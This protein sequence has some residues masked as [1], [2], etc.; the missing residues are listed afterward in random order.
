MRAFTTATAFLAETD[1]KIIVVPTRFPVP[2]QQA[3]RVAYASSHA[4]TSSLAFPDGLATRGFV[5]ARTVDDGFSVQLEWTGFA[6][7]T[8]TTSARQTP[9]DALDAATVSAASL[10]RPSPAPVKF[11][12]PS[13]VVPSPMLLFVDQADQGS[14]F[15]LQLYAVTDAGVLYVLRFTG[16][17]MFYDELADSDDQT[18]CEEYKINHFAH[19]AGV[20][21]LAHVVQEARIIVASSD[22]HT[23]SLIETELK[24]ASSFSVRSLIPFSS[25][26]A[27]GGSP[28]RASSSASISAPSQLV[29]V[30]SMT[31]Q[32]G[33]AAFSF[34]ISRDRKLK[35]WNLETGV[36]LKSI[37]LPK[38]VSGS[39]ALVPASG[40]DANSAESP[41]RSL[42]GGTLLPASPQ[43][44]V[45]VFAGTD[46]S[47]FGSY[48]ALIV[49][50][51][52]TSPSACFIYGI[53]VDSSTGTVSELMPVCEKPCPDVTA[54]LID[55]QVEQF[56]LGPDETEW[57]VF[58]VWD[59]VGEITLRYIGVP[60]IDGVDLVD[61]EAEWTMVN[62]GTASLT[63]SWTPSYFDDLMEGNSA[64][65]PDVFMRHIAC[66]GRYPSSAL[67]FALDTYEQ[68]LEDEM[69][70]ALER[71]AALSTY[72]E[73]AFDRIRAVVGCTVK[74]EQSPAT[75][76]YLYDAYNKRIKIE[77][78]KFVA[79][80]NQSRTDALYPIGISVDALR[81]SVLVLHREA[82]SA[83]IVQD[84][85]ITLRE[86]ESLP[87]ADAKRR[88]FMTSPVSLFE[89]CYPHLSERSVRSDAIGILD[90][91]HQLESSL[92]TAQQ[93][94]LDE[95]LVSRIR[96]PFAY[97]VDDI[98]M[99]LYA[100]T[101]EP[102]VD[103]E[104]AQQVD[105]LMRNL[106]APEATF[107]TLW[108]LLTTS[109]VVAPSR[110]QGK[111]VP[112]TLPSVLTSALLADAV[113]LSIEA[114]YNL[115]RGLTT[116]LLFI[117]GEDMQ[118]LPEM[119][120]LTSATFATLHTLATLRWVAEQSD[121]P[122]VDTVKTD[123]VLARF[124]DM[125]VSSRDTDWPNE[126][127]E[128]CQVVR[129][130]SLLQGLLRSRYAPSLSISDSLPVALTDSISNFLLNLGLVS[131]KRLVIDAP[132]DVTFALRLSQFG[133]PQL[134]LDFI[135][136]YPTG[137]GM[138]FV[139]GLA[140]VELGQLQSAQISFAKAAPALYGDMARL[141]EDSGISHVL[142]VHVIGSL[143]RYYRHVTSVFVE[144]G[145]DE[146]VT[147][148][149][150]LAID[151]ISEETATDKSGLQELW[152]QLFKSSATLGEYEEAYTAMMNMPSGETRNA[153]LA[154]L[155][156]VMCESGNLNQLLSFSF[157]GIEADLERNLSFRARNSD[158]LATPN[159]YAVLYAYHISRGDYRSA[160]AV[161]FQQGRRLGEYSTHSV[162][163]RELA[164]MQCQAYLAAS[165]ALSMVARDN[166]W[167]AV[168]PSQEQHAQKRRKIAP[169]IP[170]EEFSKSASF[171]P[172]MVE[173]DDLRREYCLALARLQ[174]SAEFPE[175]ERTN[176]SLDDEAVVALL[177]Q[178]GA[179]DQAFTAAR[180][181][182]VDMASLFG[183]VA[184]R[185]IALTLNPTATTDAEWVTMNEEALSWEGSLASK[186][187]RLL[188]RF[189]ARHD[190]DGTNRGRL[191]VIERTIALNR[192]ARLPTFLTEF[193]ME[194]DPDALI[195]TLLKYD[196][197]DDAFKFSCALIQRQAG[198]A[199]A[200]SALPYSLFDQLL[201]LTETGALSR[202]QLRARQTELR[203]VID[204]RAQ[205]SG[206]ASNAVLNRR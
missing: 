185:C 65:I 36:C 66:P 76:A 46:Q 58:A 101:L 41:S 165:N 79:M 174:L 118:V 180:I 138:L 184:E 154:H 90:A 57:T 198:S 122:T 25:S 10:A 201:A 4:S 91:I 99:D 176:F 148:F 137:A 146:A 28:A 82:V 197:L 38:P 31:G 204:T 191:V 67:V 133:L 183:N 193:M 202:E 64:S 19:S 164:T 12:F 52:S 136:M 70:I 106:L 50:P 142:P 172:D 56:S 109:E 199:L 47:A 177:S 150:R 192:G 144:H 128:H 163:Y 74:L 84:T 170:E 205:F 75:G 60:E 113:T 129:S 125:K 187:W 24:Q 2:E 68:T 127:D 42:K 3:P 13:R 93:R 195:R 86:I 18:W 88:K 94:A 130:V 126:D 147:R 203:T 120:S 35:I 111:A 121:A 181:L 141:D 55:F 29:A 69:D 135:N 158:P 45:K 98:A 77:W 44:L 167:I 20:P 117:C 6:A 26:R 96:S 89:A 49:P 85:V 123:D 54:S 171:A 173:L 9:L 139:K 145:A 71:P 30:A 159:Y 116:L 78:L 110:Q 72:F 1:P 73:S 194:Q 15:E 124:G 61:T 95:S 200:S 179:F 8:Q 134:V 43:S 206:K 160:G 27:P 178:T 153:C 188:E 80:L 168:I 175:L 105:D 14:T 62:R 112:S 103:D 190:V 102:F 143:G 81:Q 22:G 169:V 83:P 32:D 100:E 11:E 92:T 162:G 149:A 23:G 132:A 63:A 114:R 151:T 53:V 21:A 104:T 182:S 131:Q 7:S 157:V 156:S 48:L 189:L 37:D 17:H 161:M 97:S 39:T 51:S 196:R 140:E 155:I 107:Q 34:G 87:A 33:V 119:T 115:A 152:L 186:A 108:A 59:E 40:S 166:A 5:L 16:E